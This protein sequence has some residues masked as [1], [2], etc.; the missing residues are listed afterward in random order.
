MDLPTETPWGLFT[1]TSGPS[2]GTGEEVDVDSGVPVGAVVGGGLAGILFLILS[3]VLA[4][5]RGLEIIE[6]I[7]RKLA[8]L[9]ACAR[10]RDEVDDAGQPPLPPPRPFPFPVPHNLTV[11]DCIRVRAFELAERARNQHV[12][13]IPSREE[14]V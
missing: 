14:F 1:A 8:L 11:E 9:A 3:I 12:Y 2:A 10:D 7:T 13:A 6:C 5:K 4:V